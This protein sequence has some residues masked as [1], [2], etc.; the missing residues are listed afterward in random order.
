MFKALMH[1]MKA[2]KILP[3]I[4]ET[5]KMA[6]EAGDV[7]I[8]GQLFSGKL[9]FKDI[10]KQPYAT[11]P[12]EEQAFVDGPCN[13]LLRMCDFYEIA[14][15][16]KVPDEVMDFIK[17]KGF[18][19]LLIP[20]QYG[21]LDFSTQGISS[22]LL[23]LQTASQPV[24]TMVV[25]PNSLGAA[26]LI[27][28]YGSQEQKEHYL[29]RLA[30]GEY[31]PCFGLTEP[32]AGSDAASIKAEGIL[33]KDVDGDIKIRLNFR[34]R[35]ITLAPIATLVTL[36]CR[37]RDP[38][39]LLGGNE[40]CGINTVLI[41]KDTP[42]FE[43]GKHHLPIGE[44]FYNGPLVG[45][46]VVIPID[47]IIG[48][49]EKIG[50][51]WGMLMTQL[52]GGRAI[53]LPAGA[54][55]GMIATS[56][57]TGAYS[58]VRQ[59]FNLPIGRMEGVEDKVGKIAAIAYMCEGARVFTC[60]AIDNGTS[61][62]VAAAALKAYTTDL[63]RELISD[64]MDV[65]SG[66]GVIQ[67]PNNILG[68]A[69]TSVPVGITVEG[70][71]IMTRTLLVFGQGATRCHPYALK[72][73]HAV[74][75]DD[76]A[77]FRN[78][79][80]AWIASFFVGIGRAG[81]YGITRGW[82][83]GS[84]V[85]GPTARY[86]R[87]FA[88][89]AARFSMLANIALFALGAKLK[90]RGKLSGRFAD[91]IA[92][93]LLGIAALRRYEAEGRREEDLPLVQ[94]SCEFA[95]AQIQSAYEGIFENFDGLIGTL[96][97]VFLLPWARINPMGKHPSDARS[98]AAA[99]TI[100]TYN[101][102]YQR[103]AKGVF[104]SDDESLGVGR[105]LKAFR[106]VSRAHAAAEKIIKAQK[107]KKLP[108]GPLP[109]DLAEEAAKAGIIDASEVSHLKS[110]LD[111]RLDAIEVD[112]FTPEQY[113]IKLDEQGHQLAEEPPPLKRAAGV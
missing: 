54:V 19:G 24:G 108:R 3:R 63:A 18:M 91:V 4:S 78:N 35:Y 50:Q 89:S 110:A 44:T 82:L 8:D 42:G 47:N 70:A 79:L 60:S 55:G 94:Y 112:E 77:A 90:A 48:G 109:A 28:H 10:L 97:R 57:A 72:I 41:H 39:G 31:V 62:P 87:R 1:W 80:L 40:D 49:R 102:Q 12:P 20:K 96:M 30:T 51:G 88:W 73:V 66:A 9:D 81:L 21:G 99:L 25:I 95:L 15:T 22:V 74:D 13:E 27:K 6:L 83:A 34:K 23:K 64:G 46:D 105:L 76:G 67:G 16:R 92:Y 7:W 32:T 106:L 68:R 98:H 101:D 59:Q 38:E 52:A 2:A 84:P 58:M 37:L 65:F 86:Y 14:K 75:N 56:A 104:L 26:E 100:Q 93:S 17:S 107:A 111:A 33:F 11:L 53:S 113:F 71:N 5:E 29:P 69:Y 36:A 45:K 85:S 61:P 103:L 43:N